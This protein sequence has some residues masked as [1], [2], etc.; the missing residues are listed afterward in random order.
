MAKRKIFKVIRGRVSLVSSSGN[1]TKI[2][3]ASSGIQTKV[4]LMGPLR[5][6]IEDILSGKRNVVRGETV[7]KT[8][9]GLKKRRKQFAL[10]LQ[11]KA[12]EG[13]RASALDRKISAKGKGIVF[14]RIRGRIVPI[15]KKKR[16]K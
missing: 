11:R 8:V 6:M 10:K 1:I 15:R 3:R 7:G 9:R 5:R 4:N 2:E 13:S 14:R 12:T 16:G